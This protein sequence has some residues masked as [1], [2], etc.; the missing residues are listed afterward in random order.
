MNLSA[1]DEVDR[2]LDKTKTWYSPTMHALI[3]R[4]IKY[5]PYYTLVKRYKPET[6]TYDYFIAVFDEK[7]STG[8]PK[9]VH[10]DNYGRCFMNIEKITRFIGL[11]NVTEPVNVHIKEVDKTDDGEVYKII[12]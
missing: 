3:S 7:S 12:V 9:R 10:K 4:E 2:K 5:R 8:S 1:Y 6:R 11:I